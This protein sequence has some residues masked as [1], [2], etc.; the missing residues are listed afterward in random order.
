MHLASGKINIL[1]T[2]VTTY[3]KAS[4]TDGLTF[5][6]GLDGSG[7]DPHI[8][9]PGATTRRR[10]SSTATKHSIHFGAEEIAS[11]IAAQEGP[12]VSSSR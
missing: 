11:V 3:N 10:H 6:D 8:I 5:G 1:P 2:V 7:P 12:K 9:S 4:Q